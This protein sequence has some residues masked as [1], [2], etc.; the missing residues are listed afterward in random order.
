MFKRLLSWFKKDYAKASVKVLKAFDTIKKDLEELNN[1][2]LK[3]KA[4][5]DTKINE[6]V[7]H[8]NI[9]EATA[10]KNDKVYSRLSYLIGDTDEVDNPAPKSSK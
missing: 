1:G 9:L 3:K 8:N 6:L 5:N 7:D 10:A 4:E 2:I